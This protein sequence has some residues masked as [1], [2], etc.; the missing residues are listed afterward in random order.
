MALPAISLALL[1][2]QIKQAVADDADGADA[3]RASPQLRP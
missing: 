1:A 3:N 2:S